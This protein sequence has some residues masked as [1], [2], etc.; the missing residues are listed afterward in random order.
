[1]PNIFLLTMESPDFNGG[2]GQYIRS[3]VAMRPDIKVIIITKS[4]YRQ[5]ISSINFLISETLTLHRQTINQTTLQV[6]HILPV[7]TVV[8]FLSLFGGPKYEIFLHGL[9]FY[10]ATSNFK[11]RLLAKIILKRATR[12]VVNSN[13]LA[14]TVESFSGK[15]PL[16]IYPPLTEFFSNHLAPQLSSILEPGPDHNLSPSPS[17]Q[18]QLITVSRLVA[19]KGHDRV[20]KLIASGGI[21]SNLHYHIVGEGPNEEN[22]KNIVQ[23][24]QLNNQ[25]TFHGKVSKEDLLTL[26]RQSDIFIMPTIVTSTGREGFGMVYLEAASQALPVIASNLSGVNEAVVDNQTGRLINSDAE[27]SLVLA[28]FIENPTLRMALGQAGR[29]RVLDFLPARVFA[30]L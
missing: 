10:L 9:D 24:L 18:I 19:H 11:K 2:I 20:L 6:H 21:F 13:A 27:L 28:E 7:G 25:V 1:M 16:V 14:L 30:K 5:I 26:Y 29:K 15:T 12:V 3:L 17:T 22:L 8:W 4:S 23:D